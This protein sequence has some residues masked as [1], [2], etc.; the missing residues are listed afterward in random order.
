MSLL[1]AIKIL[2]DYQANPQEWP[3]EKIADEH[4]IKAEYAGEFT[5]SLRAEPVMEI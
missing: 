5:S 1:Q 3:I 2:T 4:K